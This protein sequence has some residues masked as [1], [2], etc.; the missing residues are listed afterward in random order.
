MKKT[1]QN[2]TTDV[3]AVQ[4]SKIICTS[5]GTYDYPD[6]FGYVQPVCKDG[7]RTA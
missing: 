4:P 1:Y 3:I 7:N 5:D 2:P 6:T